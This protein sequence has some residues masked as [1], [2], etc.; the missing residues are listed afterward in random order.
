MVQ[1]DQSDHHTTQTVDVEVALTHPRASIPAV[2][3]E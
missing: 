1:D 2:W 3:F